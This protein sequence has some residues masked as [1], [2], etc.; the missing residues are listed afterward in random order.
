MSFFCH[1]LLLHERRLFSSVEII[2][3]RVSSELFTLKLTDV[4]WWDDEVCVRNESQVL[5]S[6]NILHPTEMFL[7]AVCV[8]CEVKSD[9]K[10]DECTCRIQHV[11]VRVWEWSRHQHTNW[12]SKW[13]FFTKS[14]ET[15]MH[16]NTFLFQ[17]ER[18]DLIKLTSLVRWS[19]VHTE[20]LLVGPSLW[21]EVFTWGSFISIISEILKSV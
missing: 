9:Y 16:R 4:F 20:A 14:V 10:W 8:W 2:L 12:F 7:L 18:N 6:E 17:P 5:L 21:I 11:G 19:E 1:S 13:T 3:M 15:N